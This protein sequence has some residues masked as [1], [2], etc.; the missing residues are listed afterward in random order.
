M[1]PT[2]PVGNSRLRGRLPTPMGPTP[3]PEVHRATFDELPA[4]VLYG[5]L[6]LR[7]EVFV[8]EQACVFLDLDERDHEPDAAHLWTAEDAGVSGTVRL[9]HE[10]GHGTSAERRVGK[11]WVSRCRSRG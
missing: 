1:V 8:V 6:R 11:E 3:T 9:P 7:S 2:L 10:D 4:H 5:M